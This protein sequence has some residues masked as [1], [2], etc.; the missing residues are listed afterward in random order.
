[1]SGN[2]NQNLIDLSES[3]IN[4]LKKPPKLVRKIVESK[5]RVT[6]DTK[7]RGLYNQIK[8]LTET[9]SRLLGKMI[10]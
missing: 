5:S 8:N 2:D 7:I 4:L 10:N 9:I 1:M 6:V 3:A